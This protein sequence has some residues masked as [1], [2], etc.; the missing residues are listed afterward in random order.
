MLFYFFLLL[1]VLFFELFFLF[2]F[3]LIFTFVGLFDGLIKVEMCDFK[4]RD[5]LV[6]GKVEHVGKVIN[7]FELICGNKKRVTIGE[8]LIM[9]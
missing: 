4:E 7:K 3:F 6:F 8:I 5:G 1:L 9:V 2:V